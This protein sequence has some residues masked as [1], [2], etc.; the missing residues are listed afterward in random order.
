MKAVP[1]AVTLHAMVCLVA[2]EIPNLR[3]AGNKHRHITINTTHAAFWLA[4]MTLAWL[5]GE[6]TPALALPGQADIPSYRLGAR[7]ASDCSPPPCNM[8]LSYG[9]SQRLVQPPWLPQYR[10]YASCQGHRSPQPQHYQHRRGSSPHCRSYCPLHSCQTAPQYALCR[11]CGAICNTPAHWLASHTGPE[12]SAVPLIDVRTQPAHSIPLLPVPYSRLNSTDR[13]HLAGIKVASLTRF[14][15]GPC[16]P[17]T[18]AAL[19]ANMVRVHPPQLKDVNILQLTLT[20]G[21]NTV[22]LDLRNTEDRAKLYF[23]ENADIFI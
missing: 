14:I 7:L 1:V 12:A 8:H 13:H 6:S 19:G 9:D 5:D 10:A 23:L 18:L 22:V 2:D 20:A 3:G 11:R 4:T 16:I 17:T 21:Q 15:A